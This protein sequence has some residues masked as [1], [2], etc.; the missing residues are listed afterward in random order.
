MN[1]KIK[2]ILLDKAKN[3]QLAHLYVIEPTNTDYND[4]CLEWTQDLLLEL[5]NQ[6]SVENSQDI[7]IL[8]TKKENKKYTAE[9]INEIQNFINYRAIELSQ[10]YL[11]IPFSHKL[12]EINCNKLLKTFE[13]PPIALTV[14][15]LNPQKT[16]LLPTIKSRCINIKIVNKTSGVTNLLESILEETINF[17]D[18]N[19]K[20]EEEK[21]SIHQTLSDLIELYSKSDAITTNK[22]HQFKI[23]IAAIEQ[24]LLFHNSTQYMRLKIFDSFIKLK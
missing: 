22:M 4:F 10:K 9:D 15:L 11:L 6:R 3:N 13:E 7:L 2:N 18:F 14:F 8:N 21:Y 19:T 5:N 12:S 23:D 17:N 16:K 20:L 1:N 24:D